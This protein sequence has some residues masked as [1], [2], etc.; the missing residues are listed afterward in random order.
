MYSG[1]DCF[2]GDTGR[3]ILPAAC[4]HQEDDMFW[5][6]VIVGIA[7]VILLVIVVYCMFCVSGEIAQR[8]EDDGHGRCS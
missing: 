1:V 5:A 2:I 8:E 4:H 3:L 6:W 7:A